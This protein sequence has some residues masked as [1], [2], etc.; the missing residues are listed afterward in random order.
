MEYMCVNEREGDG[1]VQLQVVKVARMDEFKYSVQSNRECGRE[2]KGTGRVEKSVR[3]D[4]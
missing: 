2:V 1:I 3:R 4:L